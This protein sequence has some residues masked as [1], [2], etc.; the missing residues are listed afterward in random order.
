MIPQTH[1]I[2]ANEIYHEVNRTLNLTLDKTQL[3]YGSIKPDIFSGIPKLKHF[4]PQSFDVI[5]DE[6]QTISNSTLT[7]NQP[8]ISYLSQKIG[9]ITHYIADYFCIPH[10][11][12]ATYQNHFW[13]HL[14]Y[15]GSLHKSFK[16]KEPFQTHAFELNQNINFTDL[17]QIKRYLDHL[18]ARYEANEESM[19]NDV[20]SSLFAVK[21]ISL[22]MLQHA[23]SYKE[24]YKVAA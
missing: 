4:K 23:L 12:R 17:S 2:I 7:N 20:N 19:D 8:Y 11:D 18:H 15:E 24:I 1:V 9:V 10:N 6:I 22:L 5:C 13:E 14:K 21:S 16:E 3:V